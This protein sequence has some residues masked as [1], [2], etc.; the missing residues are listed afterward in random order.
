M[1]TATVPGLRLRP[2]AGEPDLAEIARIQNLEAEADDIPERTDV[3]SL[4]AQFRHPGEHF[5]PIRDVT[6][7]EVGGRPVAVAMREWVDTTD[8]LREYRVN[9]A[10][11]P[12][13]RRRGIG[14]LLLAEN[15]RRVRELAA[16]HVTP[17]PRAIGSWS[18]DTQPGNAALLAAAGFQRAR[19]FFEMVRPHLDDLPDAPLPDGL[20]LRPVTA[21]NVR[22][23]WF[24]NVEAFRDH[25]GGFDPSET[26]LQRWLDDPSNDLSLWIVAFE[27]EEV[28]G[29]VI[30]AI[31]AA[32]NEALGLHRGWLA[33]VFTRRPW[34]QRGLA[35]AL[36]VRSLLRLRERGMT[37][38]ALGVDADNPSGALG[39]YERIGFEVVYRSTAWR[40]PL[41]PEGGR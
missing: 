30:N 40:K 33:S 25:W 32:E 38:G 39:L 23:V 6:V 15:E 28:A 13:W 36:I 10:V 17:N 2:Y 4:A 12:A 3:E 34:R 5:E 31:N 21:D 35:R 19:W 24:A 20:E 18:G 26:H 11:A 8:G 16:G 9:G 22:A 37:T 14:S 1:K 27:G 29:G 41:A 7:A